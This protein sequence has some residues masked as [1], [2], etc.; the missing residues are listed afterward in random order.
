M[1]TDKEGLVWREDGRLA[2]EADKLTGVVRPDTLRNLGEGEVGF[3][4]EE[5]EEFEGIVREQ[6]KQSERKKGSKKRKK[7]A[8]VLE[9][10]ENGDRSED[11]VDSTPGED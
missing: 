6:I 5:A 2:C 9:E 3:T 7:V 11:T 8:K 1:K 10:I 4:K